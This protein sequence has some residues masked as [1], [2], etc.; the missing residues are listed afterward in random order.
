M[1]PSMLLGPRCNHDLGVLLRLPILD[2]QLFTK[3][4]ATSEEPD[5]IQIWEEA[6]K[7]MVDT[8]I[9]HE[10]YCAT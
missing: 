6:V 4:A 8:L 2:P 10:F 9:A 5:A 1:T 3:K 7:E